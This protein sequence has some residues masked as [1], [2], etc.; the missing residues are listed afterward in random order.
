VQ[1]AVCAFIGALGLGLALGLLRIRDLEPVVTA[2][3][4]TPA[5]RNVVLAWGGLGGIAGVLASGLAAFAL[6]RKDWLQR[7]GQFGQLLL[8]L[9]V[10]VPLPLLLLTNWGR[11]DT[12][13]LCGTVLV[14]GLAL[15]QALRVSLRQWIALRR[16]P[17][18]ALLPE[19]KW[20]RY[21]PN[22]A[23]TLAVLSA[24]YYLGRFTLQNH[25]QLGTASF[26]LGIF[27]NM[28]WNLL[29]G[30]WFYA[31]PVMAWMGS[32]IKYHA[33][34][35][36]FVLMPI[37]ALRQRPETLIALQ[38]VLCATAAVPLY[39]IA[40]RRL[41]S[42]WAAVAVAAAYLLYAPQHGA[43]FFDYHF[44]T[45]APFFVLWTAWAYESGRKGWFIFFLALALLNRED[46][47]IGLVG[48]FAYYALSGKRLRWAVTAAL[49]SAVYLVIVKFI[50]MPAHDQGT[51]D[52]QSF[53][54]VYQE[55][56]SKGEGGLGS[57]L[58]TMVLNPLF[59]AK[60]VFTEP[61][62]TYAA[63]LLVPVLL[64]PIR[65]GRTLLLL[66]A[67]ILLTLFSTGYD[68]VIQ[69]NFQ[70]TAHW[71]P[72]V[73][74]AVIFALQDGAQRAGR[75]RIGAGVV[76]VL[77]ATTLLSLNLGALNHDGSFKAGFNTPR[78]AW[79]AEDSKNLAD[80]R[81]L[82]AMVPP[83]A[84]IAASEREAPH[85]SSRRYCFT[86]RYGY[87]GADYILTRV[88]DARWG[89]VHSAMTDVIQAGYGH[90]ATAGQFQLWREG[91]ESDTSA[92]AA[93][94][95]SLGTVYEEAHR[96][97]APRAEEPAKGSESP[98]PVEL[99]PGAPSGEPRR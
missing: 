62:L 12:L 64:L 74:L 76:A 65:G 6:G 27:N 22:V 66:T 53:T 19:G 98:A 69:V 71:T 58:R 50:V 33:T 30:R 60:K 47:S 31:S 9:V 81:K 56:I 18:A 34:F 11:G 45:I 42:A 13:A 63:Q 73:F 79:T 38:A 99:R 32:H 5:Q 43:I 87:Q 54:Y 44:L 70:Y 40:R 88:S 93:R 26:D 78:F 91:L 29:R 20:A 86:L 36:A 67:G 15:E 23:V 90:V 41:Q 72:Y 55:L 28:M 2:N 10:A 80:L 48:L 4:W 75:E 59:L 96:T 77:G 16:Q 68:P 82:I 14:W 61:K 1:G 3:D 85:V 94:A 92:E 57:A 21:A 97:E 83:N 8:P 89:G 84:S 35:T 24:I 95:M 52:G 37:Y 46:V 17:F 49:V 39:L 51:G 25:Y 7:L